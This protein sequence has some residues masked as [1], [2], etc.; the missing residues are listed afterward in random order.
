MVTPEADTNGNYPTGTSFGLYSTSSFIISPVEAGW[1]T[2]TFAG[3]T[4]VTAK[5]A[6]ADST[7]FIDDVELDV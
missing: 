2:I 5:G 7:A 3:L 4:S 6:A 1:H